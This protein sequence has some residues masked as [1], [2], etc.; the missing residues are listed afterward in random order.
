MK[1]DGRELEPVQAVISDIMAKCS[2]REEKCVYRG[3]PEGYETVSSGL[4]RR[5]GAGAHEALEMDRLEAE[6]V[7]DGRSYATLTDEAEIL[8]EIQHFGGATNLIDFTTDYLV[9]LYFACGGSAADDGRVVLHWP[10]P[11]TVVKPRQTNTRIIS[12]KSVFVRPRRGF[13]VPDAEDETVVV[14]GAAKN[15]ILGYLDRFHDISAKTVF[16]DIHGFIRYQRPSEGRYIREFEKARRR[17]PSKRAAVLPSGHSMYGAETDLRH[18][19]H[20]RNGV[21]YMNDEDRAGRLSIVTMDGD[22]H[23]SYHHVFDIEADGVLELLT[24]M[25]ESG[26]YRLEYVRT[27]R[28]EAYLA[29][30]LFDCAVRDFDR[31]LEA[32]PE[33][34]RAYHGRGNAHI[35]AGRLNCGI[36]DLDRSV[37]LEG[38]TRGMRIELANG[39][40]MHGEVEKALKHFE[41]GIGSKEWAER[42][43]ETESP[44]GHLY[45]AM[46]FC[47]SRDWEAA[48]NDLEIARRGGLL[49]ASSFQN[50]CGGVACFEAEHGGRLPSDIA[51]TLYVPKEA[52]LT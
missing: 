37:G 42:R 16:N 36:N 13:L 10:E 1:A 14:P 33:L 9:A 29:R 11:D 51:T 7:E 17:T 43:E 41:S 38:G 8:A 26:S 27:M 50:I 40:R 2:G 25:I 35:L 15:Q 30:G 12:Q 5:C 20:R 32:Q 45:R 23:V 3:E 24:D 47:A 18:V 22:G 34:T 31:A 46:M 44:E 28:G 52:T 49:V 6:I 48:R 39:L 19:V 21:V 4:Y